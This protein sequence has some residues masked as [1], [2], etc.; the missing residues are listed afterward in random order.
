MVLLFFSSIH[1][2]AQVPSSCV[3][4]PLLSS[5]YSHDVKD[6][7]LSRIWAIRS[8]DTALIDIPAIHQ[9]SV[10]KGLAAIW[11]LGAALESDSVFGNYCIHT[12][13][14]GFAKYSLKVS[15]DTSYPWTH[16][17]A[18]L[19]TTT[20]FGSLD[21]F[22]ILHGFTVTH[23]FSLSHYNDA[24]ITTS[25]TLN[26]K[27]F[28]DSLA[29]FPG[30]IYTY[31]DPVVG[32]G[33]TISYQKDF[34]QTQTYT[35]YAG[36]GDCAAGCTSGKIWTYKVDSLCN[37]TLSVFRHG[38]EPIDYPLPNCNRFPIGVRQISNEFTVSIYPNPVGDMMQVSIDGGIN[39]KVL[40]TL[41][42]IYG[43]V[44]LTGTIRSDATLNLSNLPK[45][46]YVLNVIDNNGRT[47][48]EKVVKN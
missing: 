38:F 34:T 44:L 19:H 1:L 3:P 41:T 45:G 4:T 48:N 29:L 7:A 27:A 15:L 46:L 32:N 26:M 18:A 30:V 47:H 12:K 10:I 40:F 5:A 23:Y 36:W 31:N 39:E 14:Y 28:A 25:H 43:K 6:M 2:F 22:M 33:N 13:P 11:N 21:S 35:F 9:D 37:V 20:G 8:P 16:Q 24:T 17:W 42:D